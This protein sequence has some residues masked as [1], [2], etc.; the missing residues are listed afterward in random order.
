M[1]IIEEDA[2]QVII[3]A[4]KDNSQKM[5]PKGSLT[6]VLR[7]SALDKGA[8]GELR[9]KIRDENARKVVV[10]KKCITIICR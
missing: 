7:G 5:H 3:R 6:F 1:E 9:R 10:R 2:I 8:V 4:V